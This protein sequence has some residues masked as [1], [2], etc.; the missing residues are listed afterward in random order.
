MPAAATIAELT[1]VPG[2]YQAAIDATIEIE[3]GSKPAV[4]VRSLQRFY[5]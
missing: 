1:E 3:G 4:V 5:A 2:G